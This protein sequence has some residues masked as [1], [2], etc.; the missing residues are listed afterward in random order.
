MKLLVFSVLISFCCVGVFADWNQLKCRIGNEFRDCPVTINSIKFEP[1]PKLFVSVTNPLPV[2]IDGGMLDLLVKGQVIFWF[3]GYDNTDYA[4]TWPG[5][6]CNPP[7]ENN[8]VIIDALTTRE[9]EMD[10]TD[11]FEDAA[12]ANLYWAEAKFS[13][14]DSNDEYVRV[15]MYF[16]CNVATKVCEF[17]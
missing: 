12:Q 9:L 10:M 4:C 13:S 6:D 14:L 2:A 11:A 1:G 5:M 3:T 17:T 15:E 7:D 16:N 8:G